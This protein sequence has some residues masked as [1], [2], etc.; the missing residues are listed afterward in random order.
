MPRNRRERGEGQFGCLVSLAVLL[1]AGLI[2]YKMIPIKVKAA[3][4]RD[5]VVDEAKSAGQHNNQEI[6]RAILSKA[7]SLEMP[8]DK[9][10][11]DINRQANEI[12]IDVRYT[13]P[14]EFPGYTYQWKFHHRTQNPIF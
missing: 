9:D 13:V 11:I 7:E 5:T 2:A 4:I 10:D 3:E 6:T 8:I 12:T 14:V 1:L